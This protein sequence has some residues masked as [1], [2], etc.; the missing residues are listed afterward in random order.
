MDFPIISRWSF[1]TDLFLAIA[2]SI[3][4]LWVA[5]IAISFGGRTNRGASCSITDCS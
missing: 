2:K 3:D 4:R 1:L 5:L